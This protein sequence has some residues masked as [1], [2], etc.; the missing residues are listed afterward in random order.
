M[1]SALLELLCPPL[2]WK[3]FA[4]SGQGVVRRA[5]ALGWR[6]GRMIHE[7]AAVITSKHSG[8]PVVRDQELTIICVSYQ[9]YEMIPIL[10]HSFLAQTLQNFK[11]LIIHD[12]YDQRMD[13]ILA[14]FKRDYPE[15]VDYQFS[16]TRFNDYGHS[17]RDMGIKLADTEY[18]LITND[19]NY[20][21]PRFVEQMFHAID[22]RPEA[23]PDIV[24]CDM[25]HSHNN[26]GLR[27][28]LPY[29]RFETAP[30]RNYIDIGSFIARTELARKVGFRDKTFAGDATYFND[31]LE[32]TPKPRVIKIP[33]VLLVHN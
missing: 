23:P 15:R 16:E 21:A 30:K 12:G 13:E 14:V 5:A 1:M 25:L 3:L 24:Y 28:Q 19:D 10:R 9:R 27:W 6:P 20:Y 29:N 11:L 22:A 18:L 8:P 7:V 17:L 33:M 2:L 31:L 32:A 26:P 4:R